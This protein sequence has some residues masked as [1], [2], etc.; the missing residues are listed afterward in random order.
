MIAAGCADKNG[1]LKS[2][3]RDMFRIGTSSG[4]SIFNDFKS[5]QEK[6]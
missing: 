2:K 3:L 6:I 1:N 5:F 4:K